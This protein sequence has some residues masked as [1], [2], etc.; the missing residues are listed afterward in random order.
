MNVIWHNNVL[1]YM[2]I[3]IRLLYGLNLPVNKNTDL[4]KLY[5]RILDNSSLLNCAEERLFLL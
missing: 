4:G 1:F 2:D 5:G 3:R